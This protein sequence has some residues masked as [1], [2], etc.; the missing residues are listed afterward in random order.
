MVS[1]LSLKA[2]KSH[3]LKVKEGYLV[4]TFSPPHLAQRCL[5]GCYV[6]EWVK[7]FRV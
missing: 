1:T 6:P 2:L 3:S 7:S 5:G 4:A